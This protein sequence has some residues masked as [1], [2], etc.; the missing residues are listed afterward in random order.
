M[1]EKGMDTL[2]RAY[3]Q[4]RK[5]SINLSKDVSG[6]NTFDHAC[7]LFEE[8][9]ECDT[10]QLYNAF[11][12]WADSSGFDSVFDIGC[13]GGYQGEF[14]KLYDIKYY[15]INDSDSDY[16]YRNAWNQ[17]IIQ[18][19][20]CSIKSTNA[21]AVSNFC[22]GYFDDNEAK[23]KQLAED[24]ETVLIGATN[25]EILHDVYGKYFDITTESYYVKQSY[26]HRESPYWDSFYVLN[27]I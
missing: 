6:W 25:D 20:P 10:F 26:D 22:L 3:T 14:F 27:R 19:Y 16:F 13:A 9:Y 17:Y 12:E 23:A 4:L 18:K 24:F 15:G 2:F 7:Y 21:L 5:E 1:F 11:A 8:P